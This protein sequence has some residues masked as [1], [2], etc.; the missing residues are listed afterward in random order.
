LVLLGSSPNRNLSDYFQ[1][2]F[3]PQGAAVIGYTDDHIDFSGHS[4]VT[5]QVSGPS[6]NGGS[7]GAQTEGASLPAQPYPAPGTVSNPPQQPMQPGPGGEQVTDFAQD[8]DSGLL[9]VTPS[10]SAVD[11]VSIK[12][13][14]QNISQGLYVTATMKVSDLT[15]LPSS[16]TWRMYF[17]A[18]APDTGI[19]GP[20]GNQFS[21]GMSDRGDGF[22][23]DMATDAQGNRTYSWGMTQRN[24]DGS[25]TDT[26]IGAADS[27]FVN[28]LAKTITVRVAVSSLN[29]RLGSLGHPLIAPGSVMCGLRGLAHITDPAG[30]NLSLEDFTRG[31]TEFTVTSS[32]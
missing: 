25:I 17:S 5:R 1:V 27:G 8:Q 28:Q 2:N 10:N 12:Y 6:V 14:S 21:K 18:N 9:A 11:I 19:V 13:A 29:A 23:V 31:G 32:P 7:L 22:Y 15:V 26:R 24:T 30:V 4:Y 20:V 3:D 16:A